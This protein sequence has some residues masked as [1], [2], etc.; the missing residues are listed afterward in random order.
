MWAHK[1]WSR[2]DNRASA[3]KE[4]KGKKGETG[5]G[6]GKQEREVEVGMKGEGQQ[7]PEEQ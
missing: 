4:K 3:G 1:F 6:G 7:V 2:L 5:K